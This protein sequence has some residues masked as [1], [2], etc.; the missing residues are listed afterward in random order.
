MK[1]LVAVKH[2]ELLDDEIEFTDDRCQVDP[3][4][5]DREIS[6]GDTF[7]N[8]EALRLREAGGCG[9]VVAVTVGDE[10]AEDALRR[11]LA[12]GVDRAI[13]VDAKALDPLTL[14]HA[15]AAVVRSEQPDLVLCGAQSADSAQGA[16]GAALAGVL[17]WPVA[18]VVRDLKLDGSS[19]ALVECELEGGRVQVVQ[20]DLPAVITVQTGINEPR[21]GTLRAFRQA[22]A[23]PVDV[24]AFD[25]ATG[26]GYVVEE[27]RVRERTVGG[28]MLEGNADEVAAR[29]IR[30]LEGE[31]R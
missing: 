22:S 18:A 3:D 25:A 16:T 4:F 17:D 26:P 10:E 5:L 9:E 13:R 21:C 20:V 8:E 15:L 7:A 29:I 30:I 14:A 6:E 11:C 19:T 2:V 1:I 27:M 23:I 28:T 12:R 24:R 31:L